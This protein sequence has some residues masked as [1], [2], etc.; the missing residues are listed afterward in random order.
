VPTALEINVKDLIAR[1]RVA[2]VMVYALGFADV[3]LRG[4]KS[5]VLPPGPDLRRLADDSGGGYFE[6]RAVENL[7]A[8]FTRVAE[9]LHR[10]YWIGFVPPLR[11]GKIHQ[12]GVKVKQPGMT[13]RARQTYVAPGGR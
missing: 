9:E 8:L 4:G 6:V 12:I 10:Q 3:Q 2:D 1:V 13:V 7:G 5:R 11:D